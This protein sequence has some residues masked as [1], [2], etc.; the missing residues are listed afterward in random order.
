MKSLCAA[1]AFLI[2]L[3][4]LTGVRCAAQTETVIHAF[5]GGSDGAT[6]YSTLTPDGNG[7]LYGTTFLGGAY[8]MGT[9][10]ELS[11]NAGGWQE[12]VLF[13]FN[14]TDGYGPEGAVLFDSQGNL[15]GAT[16]SAG[17]KGFGTIYKLRRSA[18]GVWSATVLHN[19]GSAGGGEVPEGN[20]VFDRLG[21]L[22]GTTFY[23]GKF[24]KGTVWELAVTAKGNRAFK[25]LHSFGAGTDGV[26]PYAGV[27]L[28]ASGNLYGTTWIGGENNAGIVFQLA[29]AAKGSWPEKILYSFNGTGSVGGLVFDGKGNLYG[30]T[31]GNLVFELTPASGQWTETTLAEV[32]TSPESTLAFDAAGNLYGTTLNGGNN[33]LGSVFELSPQSGGGWNQIL[34]HSFNGGEDGS[35]TDVGVT[36]DSQGNVYGT[37]YAGGGTGCGGSGCGVVFKVN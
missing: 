37:A 31:F 15:Y 7:N 8:G 29:Q 18:K 21:N 6:P 23:G 4:S 17:R 16:S 34:L 11:P 27:T 32:A 35:R 22:Y 1:S 30:T 25:T 9:V 20:L 3:L 28:D 10:Y 33:R 2:T 13:S 14:G 36:L 5:T 26:N 19:F 24:G 12:T